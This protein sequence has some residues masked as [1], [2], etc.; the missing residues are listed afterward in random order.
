[1]LARLAT[2]PASTVPVRPAAFLP[3]LVA[4]LA[5]R[6]AALLPGAAVARRVAA[7]ALADW[8]PSLPTRPRL[9]PL[10]AA[11][12]TRLRLPTASMMVGAR[13]RSWTCSCSGTGRPP[14]ACS[15]RLPRPRSTNLNGTADSTVLTNELPKPRPTSAR[16]GSPSFE[17]GATTRARV[18]R[19]PTSSAPARLRPRLGSLNP[20]F[21]SSFLVPFDWLLPRPARTPLTGTGYLAWP[22]PN[23]SNRAMLMAWL[24]AFLFFFSK[25]ATMPATSSG[26]RPRSFSASLM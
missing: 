20:P 26:R 19:P 15:V 7:S 11:E 24:L 6:T 14:R 21:F 8:L 4:V 17:P 2:R 25:A 18:V 13:P 9:A 22:L 23:R 16:P 1:M 5:A 3:A 10:P 12:P